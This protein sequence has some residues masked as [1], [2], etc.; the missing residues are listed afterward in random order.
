MPLKLLIFESKKKF[1]QYSVDVDYVIPY[2]V[3]GYEKQYEYTNT[4]Q[5]F[6][7]NDFNETLISD[8]NVKVEPSLNISL[9][10]DMYLTEDI[11]LG[12]G[13]LLYSEEDAWDDN[14]LT[15]RLGIKL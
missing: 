13:L 8:E 10:W 15:F 11:S 9:N 2:S 12:S 5:S 1:S 6:F 14:W 3:T 7:G 4:R